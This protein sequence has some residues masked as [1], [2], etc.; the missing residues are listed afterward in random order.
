MNDSE[1]CTA[2]LIDF[3]RGR[4]KLKAWWVDS[5]DWCGWVKEHAALGHM[6][7]HAPSECP[8]TWCVDLSRTAQTNPNALHVR[9]TR[10]GCAW[11]RVET[12]ALKLRGKL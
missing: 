7:A 12:V 10:K 1:M 6:E 4:P 9:L 3:I 8:K 2:T 11:L 5:A